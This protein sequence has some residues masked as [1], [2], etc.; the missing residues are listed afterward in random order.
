MV[1]S[2]PAWTGR[3]GFAKAISIVFLTT[4]LSLLDAPFG[5][6]ESRMML[7]PISTAEF[8]SF[9]DNAQVIYVAGILEGMSLLT[10]KPTPA[11]RKWTD[12]VRSKTLG[13]TTKEVV[14]LIKQT[15][16]YQDSIAGAVSQSLSKRCKQ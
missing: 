16:N 8:M 3:S 11:Y 2:A 7:R 15:P 10:Y 14:A 6:G 13:E 12:C 4:T 5:F 9:S 1:R